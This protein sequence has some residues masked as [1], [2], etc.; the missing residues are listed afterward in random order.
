MSATRGFSL[1]ELMCALV[2]AGIVLAIATP[3]YGKYRETMALKQANAQVLQDVRRARQLAITRHAPVVV[4]FGAPPSVTNVTS[5]TIHVDTNGDNLVQNSE[6]VT[7]RK[8]PTG[9]RLTTVS[10]TPI[11]SLR[12]DSG[13][14]LVQTAA[15]S[16]GGS[17]VLSNRL[18]RRDTLLVSAVGVC[19]QP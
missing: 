7:F 5:Y 10:L 8:L 2:V 19:Y 15:G 1:I 6:A 12:F 11:D 17:I 3:G 4:R 18:N 9:T 14:L 16:P 13:G